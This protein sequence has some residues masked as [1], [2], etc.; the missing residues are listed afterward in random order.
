MIHKHSNNITKKSVFNRRT[1]M[2]KQTSICWGETANQTF[3][4]N[5]WRLIWQDLLSVVPLPQTLTDNTR[6][7]KP[8]QNRP[9][10]SENRRWPKVW[11]FIAVWFHKSARTYTWIYISKIKVR[12]YYFYFETFW[13]VH[14]TLQNKWGCPKGVWETQR[15]GIAAPKELTLTSLKKHQE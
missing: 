9:F 10:Y 8:L 2:R 4:F 1:K 13:E 11:Q 3:L 6:G 15:S 14:H 7:K 5:R 12:D